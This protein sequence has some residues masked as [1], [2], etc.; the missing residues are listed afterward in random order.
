MWQGLLDLFP[1]MSHGVALGLLVALSPACAARHE[2]KDAAILVLRK[3]MFAR[4]VGGRLLAV[5]GFLHMI[6]RELEG[7]APDLAYAS[8]PTSSQVC[9]HFTF[10]PE[11]ES[12]RSV[13]Q[14]V[15][16]MATP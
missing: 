6:V 14:A 16:K 9:Q 2:L 3:S 5:H 13:P 10:A 12:M 1:L 4:D 11:S 7:R 15:K 8:E